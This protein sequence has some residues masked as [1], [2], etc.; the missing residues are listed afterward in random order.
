M[1]ERLRNFSPLY[2][3]RKRTVFPR[4]PWAMPHRT[5]DAISDPLTEGFQTKQGVP[6]PTKNESSL[7]IALRLMAPFVRASRGKISSPSRLRRFGPYAKR[8]SSHVP[9]SQQSGHC[10][11]GRFLLKRS[12]F[13]RRSIARTLFSAR[14]LVFFL[15]GSDQWHLT[16][17]LSRIFE[18]HSAQVSSHVPSL[19]K[20]SSLQNL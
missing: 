9:W 1:Y 17:C 12:D 19:S 5:F 11:G 4:I 6:T 7:C 16:K 18:R 8:A 20:C 3:H 2:G 14:A 15:S 10:S 13:V